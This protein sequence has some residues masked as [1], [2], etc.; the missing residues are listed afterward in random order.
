M[1][2][3][4]LMRGLDSLLD[5]FRRWSVP[6]DGVGDN[7]FR[8]ACSLAGPATS[9]EIAEAW[10]ASDVPAELVDLWSRCT[11]ASLFEDV[12][13]G[14]WGLR[15]LSPAGSARRSAAEREARPGVLEPTDVVIGEFLGDQELLVVSGSSGAALVALPLDPREDWHRAGVSLTDFL[16]RY[17]DAA[18][19]KYWESTSQVG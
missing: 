4:L 1:V 14:Q 5:E 2:E 17:L 6:R 16:G 7:P 9:D 11:S 12:D 10:E 18:G 8:L 19:E 3:G 15:L 13:Y